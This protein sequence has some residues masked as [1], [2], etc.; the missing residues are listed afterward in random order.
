MEYEIAAQQRVLVPSLASSDPKVGSGRLVTYT[1]PKALKE[2]LGSLAS[3]LGEIESYSIAVPQGRTIDGT[4]I[5]TAAV[6]A[7][8]GGSVL[9]NAAGELHA[10]LWVTGELSHHEALAA[11]EQGIFVVCLGH[12]N[13]ERLFMDV[14]MRHKLTSELQRSWV[15]AFYHL[16]SNNEWI[17]NAHADWQRLLRSMQFEVLCSR[18]DRDP[19]VRVM[20]CP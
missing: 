17:N 3:S 2:I 1:E 7:G 5:R 11:T 18:R 20:R 4:T 6:C 12:S 19:F 10:D 13:S 14:V 15:A 8:S 16:T 9:R